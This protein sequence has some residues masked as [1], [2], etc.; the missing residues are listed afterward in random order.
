MDAGLRVSRVP[1]ELCVPRGRRDYM[2]TGRR[3][4]EVYRNA[5]RIRID[6]DSRIVCMSDC[7]RGVGNHGDNFLPNQNVFFA[8]LTYY[9][10]REFRY[11]ELG[12]GD[13]LWENGSLKR[14]V[15]YHSDVFWLMSRFYQEGRFTMLYG[16]HD[17]RKE[18]GVFFESHC[19]TYVCEHSDCECNLFTGMRACEGLVLRLGDSGHEILLVHGHQGDFINDTVWRLGRF[20]VRY[21][22]RPLELLGVYD[23][24][25]AAR[26]YKK[27]RSTEKRLDGWAEKHRV[28]VIA[29]HTHRPVLPR[30]GKSL[31]LND[32]SCVHP[33]CITAMEIEGGRVTLVKWSVMVRYGRQLSVEREVLEGPMEL[34][35]YF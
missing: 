34:E 16:N 23:P 8:A 5:R 1:H 17:R 21:L 15:E 29:G 31:Y 9:Y 28:M 27:R 14:I 33:R 10:E 20:L 19:G 18:D 4:D 7:H 26:N 35:A 30:P 24:T 22:W 6:K 13:E 11:M 25:S 32:G 2:K 12:D 3:L